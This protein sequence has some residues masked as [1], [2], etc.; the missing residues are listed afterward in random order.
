MSDPQSVSSLDAPAATDASTP[1]NASLLPASERL[2]IL[3]VR[4]MVLFPGMIVPITVTRAVSIA[5]AQQAVRASQPIGIIMQRTD[6]AGEPTAADL[7]SFG[8]IANVLRY[9][10]T[11]D[12]AHHLV[13]QGIQRFQVVEYIQET[14]SLIA[15]VRLI[16]E[17]DQRSVEIEARFAH[18]KQL[19]TEALE[20][21][22]QAPPEM[23]V[24]VQSAGSR[25]CWRILPRRIWISN[26]TSARISSKPLISSHG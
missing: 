21:L 25:Q 15:R 11:P 24:A 1:A 17:P 4:G 10:T 18:L 3:P 2:A 22:P 19:A 7:H 26:P 6:Q 9:V 5:A 8:T 16:D 23:V 12:G 20:L 14:P 13:C